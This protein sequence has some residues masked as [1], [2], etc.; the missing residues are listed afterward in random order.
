M[1]ELQWQ[2]KWLLRVHV[3]VHIYIYIQSYTVLSHLA[4]KI[5]ITHLN[6]HYFSLKDLVIGFPSPRIISQLNPH[7]I[8]QKHH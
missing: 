8:Q 3:C 4:D 1:K 2:N 6:F 5:Y 7:T